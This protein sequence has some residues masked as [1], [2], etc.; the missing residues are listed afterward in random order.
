MAEQA[1]GVIAPARAGRSH[2]VDR[3]FYI[4][5]AF[6]VILA[7]VVGFG[8]SLVDQSRRNASLTTLVGAHIIVASG[9]SVSC[10]QS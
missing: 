5:I 3:W 2:R 4:S 6:A 9:F 10:S 1:T 8:P 7:C